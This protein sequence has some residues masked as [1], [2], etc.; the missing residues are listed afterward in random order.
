MPRS[1]LSKIPM[2]GNPCGSANPC[3][4]NP[5]E[6][7]SD[8]GLEGIYADEDEANAEADNLRQAGVPGVSVDRREKAT[9]PRPPRFPSLQQNPSE[10]QVDRSVT[11]MRDNL[12][13]FG[14]DPFKATSYFK[15]IGVDV[16]GV[17]YGWLQ[18]C[19]ADTCL[20][21]LP[22]GR[23]EAF[24]TS[25]VWPV[26]GRYPESPTLLTLRA[27][28][29]RNPTGG[30][31]LFIGTYPTGIVYAD[32][33]REVDGDY[34]KIAFLP[35]GSLRLQW[36]A[37][38]IPPEL[39]ELVESDAQAIIARRGQPFE[40]S[41]SGQTVIL[42]G[43]Q[44]RP[45]SAPPQYHERQGRPPGVPNRSNPAP[46]LGDKYVLGTYGPGSRLQ[47]GVWTFPTYQPAG[48]ITPGA[49]V[50][51]IGNY[52]DTSGF[53]VVRDEESGARYEVDGR[54]PIV[55]LD[56][57]NRMFQKKN[58]AGLTAKGERMYEH[59]KEG[60]GGDPRAAEIASRT[61]LARSRTTRGLKKR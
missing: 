43:E 21:E 16:D 54:Q 24:P 14:G 55:E 8:S 38:N 56:V 51:I 48:V 41:S 17:G 49:W 5:W 47:L 6:V 45:L 19:Y 61:V 18:R 27:G 46:Q 32:R 25:S 30:H 36:S 33:H 42:G 60:Y 29:E 3:H 52:A 2:L 1:K 22:D 58:P 26:A 34:A 50:T 39:R 40:I 7:R 23:V 57:A 59:I 13:I 53:V 15:H 44:R 4:T 35:Y 20:I 10:W 12:E 11:N 31:R 9:R 37:G 28:Y